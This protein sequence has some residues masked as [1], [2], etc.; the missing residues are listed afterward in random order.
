MEF[1]T[2]DNGRKYIVCS[3]MYNVNCT[4]Y[5]VHC[6]AYAV[7]YTLKCAPNTFKW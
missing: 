3:G 4:L 1:I 2:V 5:S 7:Q 6:S